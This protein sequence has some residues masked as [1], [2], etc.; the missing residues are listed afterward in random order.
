[1]VVTGAEKH[2]I[3]MVILEEIIERVERLD[4]KLSPKVKE[5]GDGLSVGMNKR[6]K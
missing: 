6:L 2:E 4:D 3:L 5:I 1:M